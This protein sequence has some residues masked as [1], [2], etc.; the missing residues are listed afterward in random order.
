MGEC[1]ENCGGVFVIYVLVFTVFCV[2]CTVLL[3]CIFYEYLF[4]LV[5]SVLE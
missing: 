1:I 3:Y 4:I 2:I 5:V